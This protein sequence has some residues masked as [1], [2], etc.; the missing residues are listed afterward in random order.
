MGVIPSADAF[1]YTALGFLLFWGG[2]L[3][4]K[5]WSSST[6][7]RRAEVDELAA[8]RTENRKLKESL[9]AHRVEMLKSGQWDQDSLPVFIKE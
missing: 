5:W 9:H 2:R 6:S 8:F 1:L 3:V 4:G 7:K